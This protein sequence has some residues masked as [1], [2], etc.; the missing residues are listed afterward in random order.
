MLL[1]LQLLLLA[2]RTDVSTSCSAVME[3]LLALPPLSCLV[4]N[5]AA[6]AAVAVAAAAAD[7]DEHNDA[8]AAAVD[9][10]DNGAAGVDADDD[11]LQEHAVQRHGMVLPQLLQN[12]DIQGPQAGLPNKIA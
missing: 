6:G 11:M 12:I 9:D 1:A 10:D 4:D 8:A 3:V 5:A 2:A 7:V